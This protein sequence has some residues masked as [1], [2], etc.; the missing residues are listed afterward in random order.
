MQSVTGLASLLYTNIKIRRSSEMK[1]HKPK[2]PHFKQMVKRKKGAHKS[3]RKVLPR[4]S[5]HKSKQ[6][7]TG[8]SIKYDNLVLMR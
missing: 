5:K 7:L 6:S 2:D 3:K 4:K 1:L 8:L